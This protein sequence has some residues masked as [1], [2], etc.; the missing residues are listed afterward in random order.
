MKL[1]LRRPTLVLAGAWNPAIFQPGWIATHVFG[2]PVGA[3]VTAR[4]AQ[5]IVD[6]QPKNIFY[7]KDVGFSVASNRL[8]IFGVDTTESAFDAIESAVSTVIRLLP[9]TP[10]AGLGVNFHFIEEHASPELLNK[11]RGADAL[12]ER[13][14][15]AQEGVASRINFEPTVQL[16]LHRRKEAES[17]EF[18]FNFHRGGMAPDKLVDA[19]RG[20]TRMRLEHAQSI[21]RDL[22]GLSDYEILM[23][24]FES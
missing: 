23:H 18:D 21:L 15:I 17:V 6:D 7:L 1:D 13:Y 11:I 14:P 20:G 2:V 12:D 24:Q 8:E 19:I 4:L 3:E 16:N 10:I 22:Y 9:H 5:L